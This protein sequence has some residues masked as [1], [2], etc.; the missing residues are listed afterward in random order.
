V[1]LFSY[2]PFAWY[3]AMAVIFA[4]LLLHYFAK[5][6][7]EIERVAVP[8][9]TPLS[10]DELKKYRVLIPV[11]EPNLAIIDIGCILA[12]RHN[13]EILFTSIVEVPTTVHWT[14][15]T[16]RW[17]KR[18]RRCWRSLRS[19]TEGRGIPTRALVAI[20]TRSSRR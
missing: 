16:R 4:G 3:L 5:G 20:S 8:E 11:D 18:R 10:K 15:S 9:R 6:R 12:A 17:S 7:K 19:Q 1:A 14:L 13:G 2:E